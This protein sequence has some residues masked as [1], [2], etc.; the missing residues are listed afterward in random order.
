MKTPINKPPKAKIVQ[1]IKQDQNKRFLLKESI[2]GKWKFFTVEH[3]KDKISR[4]MK[5]M[6]TIAEQIAMNNMLSDS[7]TV[8]DYL[9]L[10]AGSSKNTAKERTI[11]FARRGR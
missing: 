3:S 10:S 2:K 9:L 6:N 4:Q 5:N 11:Q 8:E 7:G 1:I